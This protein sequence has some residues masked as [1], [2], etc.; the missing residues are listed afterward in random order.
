M[1]K[2]T[3]HKSRILICTVFSFFISIFLSILSI[4]VILYS[5]VLNPDFLIDNI[6]SSNYYKELKE[7]IN[8]D[9][10]SYGAA[11][12]FDKD[13]FNGYLTTDMLRIDVISSVRKFYNMNAY[14]TSKLKFEDGLY[15]GFI[16][17]LRQRNI[18][19]TPE[20]EKSVKALAD[21]CITKYKKYTQMPYSENIS[22]ILTKVQFVSNII[23]WACVAIIAVLIALIYFMNKWKHRAIRYYIYAVSASALMILFIPSVVFFSDKISRISLSNVYL[24]N[25]INSYFQ[26][27]LFQFLQIG[28]FILAILIILIILYNRTR[29]RSRRSYN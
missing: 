18:E 11:T 29:G 15:N 26:D 9:L 22:P 17:D 10:I 8:Q 13:F 25:L 28:L 21:V 12:G 6:N 19:V 1:E 23:F 3:K 24:Y 20:I 4:T 2:S 5:T 14:T 7:E 16:N 27:L